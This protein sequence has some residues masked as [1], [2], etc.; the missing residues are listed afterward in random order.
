MLSHLPLVD[1]HRLRSRHTSVTVW[2]CPIPAPSRDVAPAATRAPLGAISSAIPRSPTRSASTLRSFPT[3]ASGGISFGYLN[4]I[5]ERSQLLRKEC[6][7]RLD[8][9]EFHKLHK[10]WSFEGS[11]VW[12]VPVNP[13]TLRCPEGR[14]QSFLG[15]DDLDLESTFEHRRQEGLMFMR[16]LRLSASAASCPDLAGLVEGWSNG[17]AFLRSGIRIERSVCARR[18]CRAT[19]SLRE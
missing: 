14:L 16:V 2:P 1:R 19:S 3:P 17:W 18:R 15:R 4:Q 6:G 8:P 12:A 7:E 11:Y 5:P 10:G 9:D 13:G